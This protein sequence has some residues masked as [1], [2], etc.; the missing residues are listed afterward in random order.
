M[1]MR[2]NGVQYPGTPQPDNGA[3][4]EYRRG[5]ATPDH[6][7]N[8]GGERSRFGLERGALTRRTSLFLPRQLSLQAW[9]R[10][11][12]QMFV[13]SDS[14]AWWWGDWLVFGEER[15]PD[16]YR[17]ALAE[18]SLDYQT[19]RNY[20]WVARRYPLSRRRDKLSFQHHVVVAALPDSEQDVLLTQAEA[21]RW[22]RNE[23]RRR[24]RRLRDLDGPEPEE[25]KAYQLSV[26]HDRRK[27]W[28]EAAECANEQVT[29]W[30]VRSLDHAANTLLGF[31]GPAA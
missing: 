2:A 17:R 9:Q 19:L 4:L 20:A 24:V 23:L 14:S 26:D 13:I 15:Y 29:D 21:E 10:I 5:T 6:T 18:T 8:E 11:G 7:T 28:Q 27:R 31:D 22:S 3:D 16:R 12:R 1:E 30:I 25:A